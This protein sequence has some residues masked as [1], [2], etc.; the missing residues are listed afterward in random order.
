MN[1]L[2]FLS[3]GG[4]SACDAVVKA[5]AAG[6]EQVGFLD[7]VVEPGLAVH[8]HHAEIERVRGGERSETEEGEADW[9]L[10]ALGQGA[11]LL[12]CAG[13]RDAVA[14]EDDGTLGVAN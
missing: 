2:R 14:G 9:D 13:F 1:L 12:H 6:D 3:I 8:T 11:D 10:G 5:H 7:G 4:E